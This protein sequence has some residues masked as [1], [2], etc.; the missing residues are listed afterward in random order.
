MHMVYP[1]R[2]P[3]HE[4]LL[5]RHQSWKWFRKEGLGFMAMKFALKLLAVVPKS[6][7]R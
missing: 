6:L 4:L 3:V 1:N 5:N 7:R 2:M